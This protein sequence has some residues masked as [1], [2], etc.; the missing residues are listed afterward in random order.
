MTARVEYSSNNSGGDWWLT[1]QNWRDLEAA[2][3]KVDWV[4]D[5]PYFEGDERWLGALARSAT[6]EGL[7]LDE[8][9]QEWERVTGEWAAALGCECCGEPHNFTEYDAEGNYVGSNDHDYPYD[10]GWDDDDETY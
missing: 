7:T 5:D 3:W 4:K 1:D 2:G 6:R 8:A 9:V 10:D